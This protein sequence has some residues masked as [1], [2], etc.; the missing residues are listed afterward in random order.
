MS[1]TTKVNVYAF[2]PGVLRRKWY[3][4]IPY[5]EVAE[6]LKAGREVL[7]EGISRQ[8]AYY[9]SKKL[10]KMLGEEVDYAPAE[11]NGKFKSGREKLTVT[12]YSFFL[13]KLE[14]SGK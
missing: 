3:K 4:V 1:K 7:L 9:A 5:R 13:K 10:S 11:F 6:E 14:Q 2:E 8:L 12:G